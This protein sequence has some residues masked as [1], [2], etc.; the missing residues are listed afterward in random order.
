MGPFLPVH[1]QVLLLLLAIRVDENEP[2]HVL[3]LALDVLF[4]LRGLGQL[5][6]GVGGE[7]ANGLRPLR[8]LVLRHVLAVLEARDRPEGLEPAL[9]LRD[10]RDAL[11]MVAGLAGHQ[12]RGAAMGRRSLRGLRDELSLSQVLPIRTEL[13]D[14]VKDDHATDEVAELHAPV[15]M[16]EEDFVL[17]PLRLALHH[18]FHV[19]V[20]EE[21]TDH[22]EEEHVDESEREDTE[23][24][25]LRDQ[26]KTR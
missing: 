14:Q 4:V 3:R 6:D 23:A 26:D 22:V 10:A 17:V 20:E 24:E 8:Q 5:V 15:Q 9:E 7:A 21:W 1:Q 25:D 12:G 13:V 11:Q 16:Q 19:E 2:I 18:L